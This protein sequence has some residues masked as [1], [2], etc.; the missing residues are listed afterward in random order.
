MQHNLV[1][2]LRRVALEALTPIIA[3]RIRKDI[4]TPREVSR[5]DT[6]PD[7][8][9]PFQSVLSIL[10]PEMERAI[11]ASGAECAVDGVEGYVI[12]T[13]DIANVALAW[14]SDA[15]ALEGE[16]EGGVF[17]FDVLDCAAA[18]YAADCEAV[19]LFEAG[20]DPRLPF[21]R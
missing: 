12:D 13:V 2:H 20:N 5:S 9:K 14:R 15:V 3:N 10:V 8:R 21:E 7:L 19:G 1:R 4:P 11:T 17:F 18:F 6:A 16:I